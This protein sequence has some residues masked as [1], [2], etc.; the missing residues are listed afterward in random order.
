MRLVIR[1][2]SGLALTFFGCASCARGGEKPAP[3]ERTGTGTTTAASDAAVAPAMG[4]VIDGDGGVMNAHAP[5]NAAP[6]VEAVRMERWDDAAAALA[7]LPE[8]EQKAPEV[9]YVRARVNLARGDASEVIGWLDGLE[10]SLPLLADD[11]A[12][13]RADAKLTVGPFREAGDY[14]AARHFPATLLKASEA[15]EKGDAPMQARAACDKVLAH[16]KRTRAQEAE[17]RARRIRLHQRTPAEDATDARWI[18]VEAPDLGWAADAEATLAKLDPSHP[19]TGPELLK[20][21]KALGQ[22]GKTDD[23]LRAL[24]RIVSSKARGVTPVERLRAKGD[25]LLRARTRGTEAAKAFDACAAIGGPDAAECAFQAA[26]SLSRADHDDEAIERFARVVRTWPKTP[27]AEKSSFYG[28][29][30]HYLH[31]RW[32][33][34]VTGLDAYVK[35]YPRGSERRE[36]LR[37]RGVARFMLKEYTIARKLFEELASDESDAVAAGRAMTL[38]ALAALRDGDRTHALAR[39]T[40]V[41]TTRPLTWPALVARARLEAEKAPVPPAIEPGAPAATRSAPLAIKLPPPADLLLRIGLD[42]DAEAAMRDRESQITAGATGRTAEALCEAYGQL[43][44]ARR[45]YQVAQQVPASSL[46]K[47]PTSQTRWAWDCAFPRP[48]DAFVRQQETAQTLP[49]GLVHGVMRL[50]SGF[51]PDAVSPARAVGLLQLMP[52]TAAAVARD[53]GIPH[54][55]SLLTSP[56][57]NVALGA[58]YLREVIDK[59]HGHVPL[60]LAG[61]NGGPHNVQRWAKRLKDTPLEVFVETIPYLESRAYLGKVM[62]NF[63]RYAFMHGGEAA[64]PKVRLDY[65]LD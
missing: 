2:L 55:E 45:R 6:W 11:I 37:A 30:L 36:A 57:R 33:K 60:A 54:Q 64:V 41:A 22:G 14:F 23:A 63:A 46:A 10:A 61:Y 8:A 42:A 40:E 24:E 25:I 62:G 51:D 27:W 13:R 31:G 47:A 29:R 16:A 17:A 56:A 4:Q 39:W 52:D 20:R 15:Y 49:P 19:L 9:R 50:E 59:F 3:P 35:Q 1:L 32:S 65:D 53:T 34:A 48:Y 58:R 28:P 38:S 18:V 26:R 12:R 43:G 21:A 5:I 44:R 7:A